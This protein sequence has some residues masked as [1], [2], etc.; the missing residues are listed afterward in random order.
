MPPLIE[1]SVLQEL[2]S[3]ISQIPNLPSPTQFPL[4][5]PTTS[6]PTKEEASII[7]ALIQ[8]SARQKSSIEELLSQLKDIETALRGQVDAH[9]EYQSQYRGMLSVLPSLPPE[10][11][12]E[13]F[14]SCLPNSYSTYNFDLSDSP[15]TIARVCRKWREV[16]LSTPLLW[17]STIP[18]IDLDTNF[19]P[20]FFELLKTVLK[21]SLPHKVHLYIYG[22]DAT[23][24][25]HFETVFPRVGSLNVDVDSFPVMEALVQKQEN[26][27]H[28]TYATIGFGYEIP[29][30]GS[31][32]LGFLSQ[33]TSFD[34]IGI[35]DTFAVAAEDATPYAFLTSV[36]FQLPN[37]TSFT[38]H[39]LPPSFLRRI[40]SVAPRLQKATMCNFVDIPVDWIIPD[41]AP[42]SVIRHTNLK[43]LSLAATYLNS[44][45]QQM[46]P[47]LHLTG[48]ASL[49][50][51]LNDSDPDVLLPV[52]EQTQGSLRTLYLKKPLDQSGHQR[53]LY[54]LCPHLE[55]LTLCHARADDLRS[56]IISTNSRPC[57]SLCRLSLLNFNLNDVVDAQILQEVLTSRGLVAFNPPLFP[58]DCRQLESITVSMVDQESISLFQ[59]HFL[60][61]DEE[62]LRTIAGFKGNVCSLVFF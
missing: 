39:D 35:P 41:P 40:L 27:K 61:V 46:L 49:R 44:F 31:L 30:E 12:S 7:K 25:Q 23:K 16:C 2:F 15:W 9:L 45:L 4:F 13:I 26:F 57:P 29:S 52:L 1:P 47:N 54:S 59:H 22:C 10:V 56:L 3:S 42:T 53:T 51:E 11:L 18:T 8:D 19:K 6:C 48:L 43:E 50:M 36:D 5:S 38:G 55:E 20:G 33:V 60:K 24:I 37:L 32:T 62:V 17:L 34:L 58:P 28:L 14:L 21:R